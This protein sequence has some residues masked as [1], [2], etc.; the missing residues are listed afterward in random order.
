MKKILYKVQNWSEYNKSL[1]KRGSL[2]VWFYDG[3]EQ[4]WL[5]TEKHG[6][7][8]A[9]MTY[10][11][12]AIELCMMARHVYSLP[13]RQTR[14]FVC[15]ILNLMGLELPV[16][17]YSTLSRRAGG[18][19][20]CIREKIR[21]GEAV[22]I[23]FDSTGLKV[24]GEGEWKVRTHGKGQRRQWKKLHLSVDIHTQEIMSAV[25]TGSDTADGEVLMD[26]LDQIP[27]KIDQGFGDGAYDSAENF[28]LLAKRKAL[29][30]IPPRENAVLHQ[31]PGYP[32]TRNLHVHEMRV[33]GKKGWKVRHQ[34]H[35]RSKAETAMSR[36]KDA[37][38]ER[39]PSRKDENQAVDLFVRLKILNRFFELGKPCSIPAAMGS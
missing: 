1:E 31:A 33:Y 20:I 8:G 15:S 39:I 2:T 14:G 37:F 9:S 5:N 3:F 10:S 35:Q 32:M 18:L 17:C 7:K 27:E 26:L 38:G 22:E 28:R 23:A 36:L 25:V 13:L 4:D 29:A 12:G 34:Y 16:P 24:M 11:E 21:S 19:E 30:T 6:G